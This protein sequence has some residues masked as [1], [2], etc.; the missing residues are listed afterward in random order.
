MSSKSL[1]GRIA[2]ITGGS[3]GIGGAVAK[4]FA[5]S[6]AIVGICH[7]GDAEGAAEVIAGIEKAG[8]QSFSFECDVATNQRWR[9]L[10]DGPRPPWAGWIFWSTV[11]ALEGIPYLQTSRFNPGTA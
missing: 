6:G 7:Y 4:L 8:G 3:R 5:S 11:P 1:D 10:E 2:L 9:T